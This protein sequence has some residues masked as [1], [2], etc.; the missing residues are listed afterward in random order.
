MGDPDRIREGGLLTVRVKH[1][2]EE[3]LV[4]ASGELDLSNVNVLEGELRRAIA[5]P[6]SEVILD[7]SAVTFIDSTGLRMLLLMAKHSR[8]NGD[9]LSMRRGSGS[10]ERAIE[11]AGLDSLLP[12]VD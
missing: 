6:P 7:L 1:D 3:L 2:G 8:N 10:V 12:L 4:R 5:G 11:R 9:R